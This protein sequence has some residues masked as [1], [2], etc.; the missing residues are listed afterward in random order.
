MTSESVL[1]NATE[2]LKTIVLSLAIANKES[3]V[4]VPLIPNWIL[5]IELAVATPKEGVVK[6]GA[7]ANTNDPVPVDVVVTA[8]LRFA[9][10]GVVKNVNTLVP[11]PVILPIAGVIVTFDAAVICPCWFTAITGDVVVLP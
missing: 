9:E 8:A 2:L 1:E 10:V 6:V 5:F 3:R 4:P 7:S 11:A